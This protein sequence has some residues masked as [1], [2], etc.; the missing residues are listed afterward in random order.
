MGPEGPRNLVGRQTEPKPGRIFG[1][2][3]ENRP[4]RDPCEA[5]RRLLSVN[6]MLTEPRPAHRDATPD[7][8]AGGVLAVPAYPED[9]LLADRLEREHMATLQGD[10]RVGVGI[11]DLGHRQPTWPFLER[12]SGHMRESPVQSLS[13]HRHWG[14]LWAGFCRVPR[15]S[16][17]FRRFSSVGFCG[18]QR[19]CFC[20]R[21]LQQSG[22]R[23]FYARGHR[24]SIGIEDREL[25]HRRCPMLPAVEQ[26][27]ENL[28]EPCGP[29]PRRT[30]W[31]FEEP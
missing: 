6:R 21:V 24:E 28:E 10:A 18:V 2:G 14:Y 13:S 22:R 27:L 25:A 29:E 12:E 1:D 17:R 5:V 16:T 8:R 23:P 9:G 11:G 7:R 15:G 26:N 19:F 20:S 31:N 30:P 3:V 4:W